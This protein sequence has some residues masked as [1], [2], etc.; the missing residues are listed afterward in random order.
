VS[1]V[2]L[3]LILASFAF[4]I[5]SL[6]IFI[7]GLSYWRDPKK[8]PAALDS[9]DPAGDDP[10]LLTPPLISLIVAVRNEEA[11]IE[12]TIEALTSLD[13]PKD[14]YEIIVVEDGS[15]DSTPQICS[16]L[17]KKYPGMLKFFHKQDSNG[18]PSALNFGLQRSRGEIIGV[19]DAD[20]IP[21]PDTLSIV[22]SKFSSGTSALQGFTK[23]SAKG[24]LLTKLLSLEHDAWF[25]VYMMGRR[26]LSLFV[27]F[28]GN[29]QFIRRD[30]VEK[31]GGWNEQSLTEDMEISVRLADAGVQVHYEPSMN[32]RE[33]VPSSLGALY[34]QRLRWFRG[35]LELIIPSVKKL[36]GGKKRSDAPFLLFSPVIFALFPIL[37]LIGF[38]SLEWVQ[39][40]AFWFQSI[41]YPFILFAFLL[42][43]IL[44]GGAVAY[45]DHEAWYKGILWIP[46]IFLYWGFLNLA[47]FVSLLQALVKWPKRWVRTSKKMYLD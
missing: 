36:A 22:V 32:C 28:S 7:V 14:R 40:P 2:T 10:P 17:A 39:I 42:L 43:L 20:S 8:D 11:V 29:C 33:G 46:M 12:R 38:I 19:F 25:N 37:W 5:Y 18:K 3:V 31:M 30:L 41:L 15:T 9:N 1:L 35:W 23:S 47:A 13:Y 34:G 44:A 6:I 24:G 21:A 45:V 16:E 27:P 26:R 4:S